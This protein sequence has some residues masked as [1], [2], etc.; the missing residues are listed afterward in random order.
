MNPLLHSSATIK[1]LLLVFFILGFLIDLSFE[2]DDDD[3]DDDNNDDHG[4]GPVRNWKNYGKCINW[5]GD[6]FFELQN[7]E[8]R[9]FNS[10]KQSKLR[11]PENP[12]NLLAI[13]GLILRKK[14]KPTQ[15]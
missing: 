3:D 2:A 15:R 9:D 7:Y 6:Y 5:V 14:N 12:S 11:M 10:C 4:D 13:V 1:R 8:V